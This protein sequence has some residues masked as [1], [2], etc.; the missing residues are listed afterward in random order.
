MLNIPGSQNLLLS[1]THISSESAVRDPLS[2]MTR[3]SLLKHAI[4]LLKRE[5][6]RLRD[7][8]GS[9]HET[10]RAKR[11]P[12]EEDLC[13]KIAILRAYHVWDDDGNDAVP[14]PVGRCG[15]TDTTGADGDG[16]DLADDD[17]GGGAPGR[18]EEEDV[19][20][21]E[22]DHGTGGAGVLGQGGADGG[23]DELADDHSD[24]AAD[25][26]GAPAETFD[27]PE[28]DWGGADV[29]DGED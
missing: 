22:G 9:I 23:D 6:L 24:C 18:G 28:G 16:V 2:R 12:D 7:Q 20:A 21:D 15:Q 5:A 17:P 4:N 29:D 13:S 10:A 3:R 19:E 14:Q 8:E 26:D 1:E 27:G 25:E 11:S